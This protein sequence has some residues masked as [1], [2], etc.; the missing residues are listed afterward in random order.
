MVNATSRLFGVQEVTTGRPRRAVPKPAVVATEDDLTAVSGVV[1]WGPLLDRFGLVDVADGLVLRQVGPRGYSGG[2]CYRALVETMLAGGDFLSDVDLLRGDATT[3]LR[4]PHPLP[5]H[6]TLWRFCDQAD[7]GRVAKAAVVNRVM[8]ARA[9]EAG[10]APPPGLLT[11]DPDATRVA[12]YG[13]HKQ[14]S[15]FS[16][17]YAG[18]CLHPLV[19]V[20]AETGEV[21]AVRGRAGAANAGR[22]MGSFIDECVAAIPGHRRGEY[23]LW[24]R[25]DSA[26]YRDDVAEAADR[27]DAWFTVTAKKFTNVQA[28]IERL[29]TDPTTTWKA[30]KG[31]E[32]R[33]GSQIAETDFTFA[34]R[35]LRLVV[36]RQP[37]GVDGDAQ[38]SIDDVAE[39]RFHAIITNIPRTA[40]TAANLEA[41][42]RL[43]GGIPEDAIRQLKNDY[44]FDHAPLGDF[45]GN[46]LW[47]HAAALAYNTSVWL[48]RL[49]LPDAFARARGKRLRLAFF[50]VPARV[51]THARRL[52]LRFASGYHWLDDFIA[53]L[54]RLHALPAFR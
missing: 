11:I 35:Q 13:K 10:G 16:Y 28:A 50:N 24:F 41:H 21:C 39:W 32:R 34:G 5:S 8:I 9:W 52:Q 45:F 26:G 15:T 30:A 6:D 18:T 22:A 25:L 51:G 14:G 44:G 33:L 38:L 40:R 29:V 23:R 49:A 53:A 2:E 36:R 27:H 4:G 1:L 31:H 17:N 3:R 42:H 12:T 46:W 43:R 7:L 48:R 54:N 37:V 47:Q 19:G 20:F